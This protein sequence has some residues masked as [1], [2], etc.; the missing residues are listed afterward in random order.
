MFIG[1]LRD[2]EHKMNVKVHSLQT[3]TPAVQEQE[4]PKPDTT[5]PA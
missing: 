1:T 5:Q 4:K 3:T 2:V